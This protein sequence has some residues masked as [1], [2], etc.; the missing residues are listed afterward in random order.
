[1]FLS[2]YIFPFEGMLLPLRILALCFP[3]THMITV[4]RGVV[5]RNADLVDLWRPVAALVLMSFVLVYLGAK[6]IKVAAS[7]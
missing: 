3:V 4:I 5:L 7:E 2:G 1:V 6:S